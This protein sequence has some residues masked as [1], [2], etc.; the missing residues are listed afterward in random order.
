MK[1]KSF[2]SKIKKIEELSPVK[3]NKLS[4]NILSIKWDDESEDKLDIKYIRDECP[5]VNCKGETVLFE[6]YIPLKA[7]FKPAGFYEIDK[8][9]TL[10]NYALHIIWKDGHSSGIYSYEYLKKLAADKK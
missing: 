10:G 1:Y 5:C 6:S 9:E 8:I 2:K 3:I 7:V 4:D